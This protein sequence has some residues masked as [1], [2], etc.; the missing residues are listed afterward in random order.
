MELSTVQYLEALFKVDLG[1]L[2]SFSIGVTAVLKVNLRSVNL[3]VN[4][5]NRQPPN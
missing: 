5:K 4:V 2:E 1:I 3:V